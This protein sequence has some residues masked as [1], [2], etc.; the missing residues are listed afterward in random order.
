MVFR[1]CSVG[2]KA[3][4]GDPEDEEVEDN[5]FV[6][7]V[8]SSS[9]SSFP[10]STSAAAAGNSRDISPHPL[11]ASAVKLSSGVLRHFRDSTLVQ[12]LARAID[13]GPGT[14]DAES[15]H[16]LEG[17]FCVLALCHTVLTAV[18]PETGAIEYKAQSPDEAALVQAAADVGFVFRGREKEVLLSSIVCSN[19]GTTR[20]NNSRFLDKRT[21]SVSEVEV[22]RGILIVCGW[23][24]GC[25][26]AAAAA[27]AAFDFLPFFAMTEI[28]N[29]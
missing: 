12:D 24:S 8:R 25:T 10:A 26:A 23:A 6:K 4:T 7:T 1:Q 9:L 28:K 21:S 2:G 13:A 14:E 22:E 18:D 3:Y 5:K 20:S 29:L 19:L 16:S 27:A 11:E 15:A 17:F